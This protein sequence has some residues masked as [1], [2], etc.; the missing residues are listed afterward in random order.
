MSNESF[1]IYISYAPEDTERV[2]KI[3]EELEWAGLRVWFRDQPQN[4]ADSV[5]LIEQAID[6][7]RAHLVVWSQDS[8]ASGRIQ[9]EARASS[10]KGRLIASRIDQ[11]LPPKG[12]KAVMYADLID[13]QGGQDHRGFRKVLT[14]IHQLTGKGPE[15][16]PGDDGVNM[17]GNPDMLNDAEKDER[18]WQ[19][20]MSYN[21]KTYFEY[22]LKHFPQGKHV[23]EAREQLEKK[24][25]TGKI[26]LTCAIIFFAVQLI[27][28]IIINLAQL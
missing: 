24:K 3:A 22:Y 17:E 28:S 26:I 10:A 11:V 2:R 12:T 23:A 1:D 25:R 13:W 7:H 8:A 20:T 21:N 4:S 18:A 14:A 16:A 19:I 5:A 27:F 15:P 6:S 9:A